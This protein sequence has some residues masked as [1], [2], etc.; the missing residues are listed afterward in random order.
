MGRKDDIATIL[1]VSLKQKKMI[2][3]KCIIYHPKSLEYS[4][5]TPWGQKRW[6]KFNN[7]AQIAGVSFINFYSK[8]FSI[9]KK[10]L[11]IKQT[12]NFT[13]NANYEMFQIKSISDD[14]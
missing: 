10:I 12:F 6:I 14:Q 13:L 4:Y 8:I 3:G 5:S 7:C 1:S 2:C 11:S 9:W